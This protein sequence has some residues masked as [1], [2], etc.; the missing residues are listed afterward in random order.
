MSVQCRRPRCESCGSCGW[1][2]WVRIK[3]SIASPQKII[4]VKVYCLECDR[5][6]NRK[7][8]LEHW[9]KFIA[10]KSILKDPEGLYDLIEEKKSGGDVL[11]NRSEKDINELI[12]LA[13]ADS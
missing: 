12:S 7:G 4:G 9:K 11:E 8:N 13:Q 10:L 5:E 1:K 2:G 6:L 3:R